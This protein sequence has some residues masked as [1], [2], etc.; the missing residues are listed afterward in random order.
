MKNSLLGELARDIATPSTLLPAMSAAL[1]IGLLIIVIELSLASLIFSGPLSRFAAQAS[2]MTLFGGFVMCLVIALF[3]TLPASIAAPQDSPA[4]ILASSGAGI[5][6]M[7][8]ASGVPLDSRAAFATMAAAMSLSA[9]VTG[10]MFLLLGRFRLGNMV[11]YIPFPVVGG[12]MAGVGWLLT[13]GSFAIMVGAPL[14]LDGLPKLL[15][16]AAILRWSPGLAMALC[17]QIGLSRLRSAAVLPGTLALA[18]G[19][20]FVWLYLSGQSLAGAEQ[21]GLLL[22]G[23]PGEGM[24]WPAFMPS[25]FVLVNWGALAPELPRLLTIP[26]VAVLSFMLTGSGLETAFRMDLDMRRDM[27]ANAAAN[28]LSG[29]SGAHAGYTALGM[30][31]IGSMTGVNSRLVGLG[32]ALLTGLATFLG[33][34]VLG[35]VPRFLLGGLVLFMGLSML[36]DWAW[37]TRRRV[38]FTEHLVILAILCAIGFFGF[39]SG[40]AVGLVLATLLFVVKYSRI[41]VIRRDEDGSKISSARRRSVPDRHVLSGQ[42]ADLRLLG[43]SGFLFFGSANTLSSAVAERLAGP[44]PPGFFVLDFTEVDGLDSSAMNSLVRMIQ[45]CEV[46]GGRLVFAAAPAALERELRRSA[47]AEA[48]AARFMPDLD[49]ALEWCEDAI[50]E[51]EYKR[52]EQD[53]AAGRDELFDNT[54]DDMLRQLEQSERFEA[55]LER[56]DPFLE[57]RSAASGEAIVRQGEATGGV[58]LF[59]TGQAEEL[60]READGTSSRLRTI[61]PGGMAGVL[62]AEL[63]A[64]GDVVTQGECTLAFLSTAS[65]ARMEAEDPATALA[66]HRHY[67]AR[68]EVRAATLAEGQA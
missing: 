30:S 51:R 20:F 11:R 37:A 38:T 4:A 49:R 62:G 64:S 17:L 8:A 50:L 57:R 27:Y 35:Y 61:V 25:D 45:R 42:A 34:G 47:P 3:S 60:L 29:V 12:F 48:E 33:A 63:A 54:V 6:S 39:L 21:A 15:E 66:F 40:V 43:V 23:A 7:L 53:R 9:L 59:V 44:T 31:M 19:G 68:L 16:P 1:V 18:L 46:A 55:L 67:T 2:G 65:L 13:S 56:M 28:F 58:Y 10:C 26:L 5:A 14:G 32:A 52:M 36:L 24:L 22:G 41:P